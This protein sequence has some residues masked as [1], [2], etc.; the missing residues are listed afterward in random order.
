MFKKIIIILLSLSLLASTS[1]FAAKSTSPTQSTPKKPRVVLMPIKVSVE[2]LNLA[3]SMETALVEGLQERYIV[4]S[5]ER[6]QQKTREIF[7]KESKTAKAECDETKCME[8]IAIAF[9]AELIAVANV[10]RRDGGYFLAIS[11]QNIFD[12]KVIY[13]K[14]KAYAN[15]T[16]FEVIDKLKELTGT[17]PAV[18]NTVTPN[19]PEV[20]QKP[21]TPVTTNNDEIALWNEI[22]STNTVEDYTI[23][24]DTYP[25]GKYTTLAK[26]RI[27]KLQDEAIT[28]ANQQAQAYEQQSWDTAQSTNTQASY[29]QYLTNYPKGKFIALAKVKLNKIKA[30]LFV[31]QQEEA[32]NGI[33]FDKSTGLT[34]QDNV[35]AKTV[36]KDWQGAMDYCKNLTLAGY[37]DWQLP[38]KDMLIDLSIKKMNL[39]NLPWLTLDYWSSSPLVSDSAGAWNVSLSSASPNRLIKSYS[40]S[41]RCVHR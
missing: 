20:E 12:N 14:S 22:Q 27:K 41:V 13:T 39:K 37:S 21:V 33:F 3:G 19:L 34:W 5:G 35:E 23:Y 7:A 28:K 32:K 36:K 18:N 24:L 30:A 2:D 17:K 31:K 40:G 25:E 4:F 16:A 26:A 8:D 29:N 1:T 9:Q 38:D 10:T 15:Q 11:I 6:V